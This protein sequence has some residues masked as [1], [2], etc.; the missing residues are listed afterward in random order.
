MSTMPDKPTMGSIPVLNS[1]IEP[2]DMELQKL[3]LLG[4]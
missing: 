2:N 3:G 1:P 4:A